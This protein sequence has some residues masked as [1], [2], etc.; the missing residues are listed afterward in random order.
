MKIGFLSPRGTERNQSNSVFAEVYREL[1]YVLTFSVDDIEFIPN[2]GLLA[3][4]SMLPSDIE[5]K[6]IDEDYIDPDTAEAITW[7]EKFD[8]V[9][10]SACNNQAKRAYQ[11]SERFRKRGIPVVIGGYHPSAL[12]DEVKEHC[13]AVVIGEGETAIV[14][15]VEDLRRGALQPFYRTQGWVDLTR[16]PPPRFDIIGDITRFNK[17]PLHATRGCPWNCKFCSIV[18]IFGHKIRKKTVDQV[19]AEIEMVKAMYPNPYITFGDENMFVDRKYAKE[20]LRR[21]VPLKVRW[22]CYTDVSVAQDDELLELC[23]DSHCVELLIG[24]ESLSRETL[25]EQEPWKAKQFDKY[26]GWVEAIRKIQSFDVGVMGLF[27]V[28]FDQDDRGVFRRIKQFIDDTDLYDVD[29]AVLCPIP[30]TQ[31]YNDMKAKGRI[32]TENWDEYTWMHVNFQPLQMTPMELQ[33]G[34]LWLFR[35]VCTIEWLERRRQYMRAFYA[36]LFDDPTRAWGA[37]DT[38]LRNRLQEA[39]SKGIGASHSWRRIS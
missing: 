26:D 16:V 28:G 36:R 32:L 19:I 30:G 5:M 8:L 21:M 23:R 35:E 14:R 13:D 31:I 11:I 15:V 2:L 3:I 29:F 6:Y 27:I 38:A 39:A 4:A 1:R 9:C 17:I 12:P 10:L 34:L 24:L 20:L 22:E 37:H 33:E 18:P 7:D 25:H